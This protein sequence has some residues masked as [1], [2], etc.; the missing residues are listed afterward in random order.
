MTGIC[1]PEGEHDFHYQ[2][3]S[4]IEFSFFEGI[5]MLYDQASSNTQTYGW[6]L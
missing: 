2:H 3:T 5:E 1:S 4:Q 6:R